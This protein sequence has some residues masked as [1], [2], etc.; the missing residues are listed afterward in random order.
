VSSFSVTDLRWDEKQGNKLLNV[1]RY[2]IRIRK[3]S[4]KEAVL[5]LIFMV[6]FLGS[7]LLN[8]DF[9]QWYWFQ[10]TTR[11]YIL[12]QEFVVPGTIFKKTFYDVSQPDD[13]FAFLQSPL[14]DALFPDLP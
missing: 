5:Y 11:S 13:F 10:E 9:H 12:D 1:L 2:R 14:R 8:S 3:S 4:G 7:L 6:F